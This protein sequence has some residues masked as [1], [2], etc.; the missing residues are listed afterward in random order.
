MIL[1]WNSFICQVLW[2]VIFRKRSPHSVLLNI[3]NGI[4]EKTHL[5]F[6]VTIFKAIEFCWIFVL[7]ESENY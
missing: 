6:E 1:L 5:L 7:D 2:T 4:Y 3:H